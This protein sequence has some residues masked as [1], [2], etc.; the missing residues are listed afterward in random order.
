MTRVIGRASSHLPDLDRLKTGETVPWIM[1]SS[2]RLGVVHMHVLCESHQ[3]QR[4]PLTQLHLT[5][6]ARPTRC[7]VSAAGNPIF[8]AGRKHPDFW[9]T[10]NESQTRS[11]ATDVLDWRGWSTRRRVWSINKNQTECAAVKAFYTVF[12]LQEGL[13][14]HWPWKQPKNFNLTPDFKQYGKQYVN[15]SIST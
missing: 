9:M 7:N 11:R 8:H 2:S 5:V 3:S 15:V 4:Q 1:C 6:K 10:L 13:N 12:K 14:P